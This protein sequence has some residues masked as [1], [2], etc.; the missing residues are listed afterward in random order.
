MICIKNIQN[1]MAAIVGALENR[2]SWLP[3]TL[4]TENVHNF[5]WTTGCASQLKRVV[6]NAPLR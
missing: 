2:S 4:S 3:T 5:F 6:A 1:V